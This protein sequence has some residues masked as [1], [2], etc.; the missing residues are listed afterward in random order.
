MNNI[1]KQFILQNK[2][3]KMNLYLDKGY[4][5][6]PAEILAFTYG[7]ESHIRSRG[8]EKKKKIEGY[9]ARSC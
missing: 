7:Y 1:K 4:Y 5:G 6:A 9:K 3:I 2:I 8:E